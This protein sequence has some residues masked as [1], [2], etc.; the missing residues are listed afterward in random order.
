MTL[1]SLFLKGISYLTPNPVFKG[2]GVSCDNNITLK[3]PPSPES[4]EKPI[5]KITAQYKLNPEA[6]SFEMVNFIRYNDK[7]VYELRHN[8]TGD[9]L[10]VDEKIFRLLFCIHRKTK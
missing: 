1:K 7:T 4:F 5:S 9:V 3:A 8:L 10:R 6:G 2:F